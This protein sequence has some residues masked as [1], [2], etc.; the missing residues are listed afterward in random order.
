MNTEV[1]HIKLLKYFLEL[2][3][4]KASKINLIKLVGGTYW[5]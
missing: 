3:K 1:K 5:Y 4:V 2:L